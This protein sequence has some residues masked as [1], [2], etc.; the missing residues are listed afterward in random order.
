RKRGEEL[1]RDAPHPGQ[2]ID[3][4]IPALARI[5]RHVGV[6]HIPVSPGV[7]RHLI[8]GT[9]GMT[10]IAGTCGMNTYDA[11]IPSA[12]A[13]R[14]PIPSAIRGFVRWRGERVSR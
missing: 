9:S 3:S 10:V 5:E 11:L 6:P 14:T 13:T 12:S 1:E 8:T 7:C 4:G 2:R